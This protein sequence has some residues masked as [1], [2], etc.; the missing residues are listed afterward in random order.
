M[1]WMIAILILLCTLSTGGALARPAEP[2]VT[3]KPPPAQAPFAEDDP[4]AAL[5]LKPH[6]QQASPRQAVESFLYYLSTGYDP[7][8]M[9]HGGGS[10]GDPQGYH[11]AWLLLAEPRPAEG[12]FAQQ[13]QGTAAMKVLQ[14]EPMD[15]PERFFVEL[16]RLDWCGDR[17]AT[18]FYWGEITAVKTDAG[19]RVSKVALRP[20]NLVFSN[21]G[22]H[23]GWQ[24][25]ADFMAV[26]YARLV[27]PGKPEPWE[28][29]WDLLSLA[30]QRRSVT[31]VVRQPQMK[32]SRTVRMARVMEG[33]WAL[34]SMEPSPGVL[35][36]SPIP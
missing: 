16:Q 2:R 13:W 36:P 11:K 14:I 5:R 34:L 7:A 3:G 10:L 25:S 35:P 18:S 4:I 24:H 29:Q 33:S 9:G 20:E 28:E 31:A 23:Q 8:V 26:W 17:W 21:V 30:Y 1:R 32:E 22:G 6:A 19:W 12:G 27:P 15:R